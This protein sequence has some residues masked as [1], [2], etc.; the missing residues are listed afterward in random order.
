MQG[1][2]VKGSGLEAIIEPDAEGSRSRSR[3]TPLARCARAQLP[4]AAPDPRVPLRRS[5]AIRRLPE[6]PEPAE[7]PAAFRAFRSTWPFALACTAK[8]DTERFLESVTAAARL[9]EQTGGVAEV[10]R[11]P[12][13]VDRVSP[14][15]R[16]TIR[17]AAGLPERGSRGRPADH[18]HDQMMIAILVPAF[19]GPVFFF[20]LK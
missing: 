12:Y 8:S 4:G 18:P 9:P 16:G 14:S 15:F 10:A 5:W 1:Q 3:A 20:V 17:A 6:Q 7:F 11:Q 2:D 19:L 13:G